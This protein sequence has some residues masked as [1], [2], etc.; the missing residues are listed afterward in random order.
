MSSPAPLVLLVE[1][2]LVTIPTVPPATI[3]IPAYLF[4]P[5]P[6]QS[7]A[8]S[9]HSNLAVQ[10]IHSR[11]NYVRLPIKFSFLIYVEICSSEDEIENRR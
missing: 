1:V 11:L 6:V 2:I 9:L 8:D 7:N 4:T 5:L 3:V 10:T